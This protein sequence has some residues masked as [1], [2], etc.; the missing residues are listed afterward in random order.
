MTTGSWTDYF[1]FD[2]GQ[3]LKIEA[4]VLLFSLKGTGRVRESTDSNLALDVSIPEQSILGKSIPAIEIEA[5]FTYRS[6]G[7]GNAAVIAYN[8]RKK[9]DEALVIQSSLSDK[10]RRLD[11][12][13]AI[14]GKTVGFSIV[15]TGEAKAEIRDVTGLDLPFDLKLKFK[16]A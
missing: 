3:D 1:P 14:G 5:A 7:A 11:P 10:T 16:A 6:E 12:S 4:K 2:S 9:Q 15:R 13:I 8:G